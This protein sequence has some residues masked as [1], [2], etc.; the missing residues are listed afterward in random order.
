MRLYLHWMWCTWLCKLLYCLKW[1]LVTAVESFMVCWRQFWYQSKTCFLLVCILSCT[2][3]ELSLLVAQTVAFDWGPL[4]PHSGWGDPLSCETSPQKTGNITAVW[5]TTYFNRLK[6][7]GVNQQCNGENYNNSS[8]HI[9]TQC[10]RTRA[11]NQSTVFALW[12]NWSIVCIHDGWVL[13]VVVVF[14]LLLL[15]E[16]VVVVGRALTSASR[17]KWLHVCETLSSYCVANICHHSV[18][19]TLIAVKSSFDHSLISWALQL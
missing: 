14:V 10:L 15:Y 12:D 16:S 4:T 11:K 9:M 19:Q 8:V 17:L 1:R 6:C 2:V 5:C 7:L 18:F 13:L 3:S